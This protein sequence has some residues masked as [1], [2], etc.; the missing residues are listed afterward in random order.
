MLKRRAGARL[1]LQLFAYVFDGF[2]DLPPSASKAL[3]DVAS[4]LVGHPFVVEAFVIGQIA[5]RL[6][7]LALQLLGFAIELVFVHRCCL[8]YPAISRT[9]ASAITSF[10]LAT[11]GLPLPPSQP[12]ATRCYVHPASSNS[13]ELMR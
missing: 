5:R 13:R 12:E 6:L 4:G 11:C 7:D 1:A 10:Q 9:G 3:L 2:S 8:P